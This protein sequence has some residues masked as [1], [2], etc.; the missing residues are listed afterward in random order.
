MFP[1][2]V[3][4]K[5]AQSGYS[6]TSSADKAYNCIAFAVG[7]TTRWWWPI[8]G[9]AQLADAIVFWPPGASLS[10]SLEA[11]LSALSLLGFA[12]SDDANV[13]PKFDKM[14]LDGRVKH[15]SRQ[16]ATG[17]WR[18]KMGKAIDIEHELDAVEGPL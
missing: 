16:V 5:L 7:D 12:P 1:P 9:P 18:S 13:R 2:D 11:F 15:A 8:R 10:D 14:A 4:P 17:R 3:F 6:I